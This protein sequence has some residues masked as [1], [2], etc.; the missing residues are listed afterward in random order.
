MKTILT[1]V[2]SYLDLATS[3]M[4]LSGL[5]WVGGG[6]TY[7]LIRSIKC[8]KTILKILLKNSS[9]LATFTMAVSVGAC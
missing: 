6:A 9:F 2:F 1:Q 7:Q 5:G 8:M 4:I 3:T